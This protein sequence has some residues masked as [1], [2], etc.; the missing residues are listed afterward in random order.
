MSSKDIRKEKNVCKMLWEI[1]YKQRT[2]LKQLWVFQWLIQNASR[3]QEKSFQ[4]K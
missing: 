4:I 2:N 3:N 1:Q